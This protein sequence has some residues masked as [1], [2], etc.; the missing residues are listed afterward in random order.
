MSGILA[1]DQAT[2][3]GW[4][5]CEPGK[6]PLWGRKRMGREKCWEGAAFDIFRTFLL[7]RISMLEPDVIAFEAPFT[8]QRRAKDDDDDGGAVLNAQ[9]QRKSYGWV[10]HITQIAHSLN[11]GCEEVQSSEFTKMLTG[12]GG[13]WPGK[14]WAERRK[15]KKAAVVEAIAARGWK[16]TADEADA[17]GILLFTEKR[18]YPRESRS[19]RMVLKTPSGPLFQTLEMA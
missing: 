11:L 2:V 10:A 15:A 3:V 1:L 5:W 8:P 7:E 13:G 4:A 9:T 18:L 19:R 12:R 6:E 17:L 14:T 16:V